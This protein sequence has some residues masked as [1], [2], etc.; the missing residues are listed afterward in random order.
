MAKIKAAKLLERYG[1]DEMP[2]YHDNPN[3]SIL[4]RACM[5]LNPNFK[6]GQV[7]EYL[8]EDG[9]EI[10]P[11]NVHKAMQSVKNKKKGPRAQKIVHRKRKYNKKPKGDMISLLMSAKKFIN[12]CGGSDK[13]KEVITAIQQLVG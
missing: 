12:E 10:Q 3:K 9:I 11:V 5:V 7:V 4:I 2:L 6:A 13:A 8:A 1:L